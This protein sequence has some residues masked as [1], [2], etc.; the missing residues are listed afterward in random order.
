MQNRFPKTS[1]KQDRSTSLHIVSRFQICLD[2]DKY[3]TNILPSFHNT[4]TT[5]HPLEFRSDSGIVHTHA[6]I[7]STLLRLRACFSLP[8]P[9]I[10]SFHRHAACVVYYHRTWCITTYVLPKSIPRIRAKWGK[11]KE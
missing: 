5:T 11:S 2:Y 10:I 3:K 7:R 6:T 8:R 9:H 1:P 4:S